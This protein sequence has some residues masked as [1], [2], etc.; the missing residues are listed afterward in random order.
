MRF[1]LKNILPIIIL[2]IAV[3]SFVYAVPTVPTTPDVVRRLEDERF[4]VS[5][6][7]V[8]SLEAEAGNVTR[9]WLYG[10][11][12]TQTWQGFY[13]EIE[14]TITLD[15]AQNWTFYDWDMV[16][17]QGEIY[18][19]SAIVTNWETVHCL[20]Y[21]AQ[22]N[23]CLNTSANSTPA[24]MH[25]G[26][27]FTDNFTDCNKTMN[28]SGNMNFS[29]NYFYWWDDPTLTPRKNTTTEI[30]LN[31]SILEFGS[32][33]WSLGL[34]W[35]DYDG[36]DETFNSSGQ[37]RANFSTGTNRWVNHSTFWVGSIEIT[38]G[39]CPATDMYEAICMNVTSPDRRDWIPNWWRMNDTQTPDLI[40]FHNQTLCDVFLGLPSA[41]NDS[42]FFNLSD[43]RNGAQTSVNLSNHKYRY[44]GSEYGVNFQEV[45]LTVNHSRTIIYAT[46]IE[47][48]Q[49]DNNTD[50]IGFDNDTHDFQLI[51]G[52]DGHAGPNQDTTTPYYFYVEIE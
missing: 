34:I 25:Q 46:I 39:T 9:I 12:Q 31:L 4:N 2:L 27:Y 35:N 37:I 32:E 40:Q 49:G 3:I 28:A 26:S 14:G 42:M 41:F 17:P 15:D 19:A 52:D 38:Q 47:N 20:N 10:L 6:H 1:A 7:G 29:Y 13:G 8:P 45:L 44:V 16:E 33:T 24:G 50:V 5:Q 21:T 11:T 18:A 43:A 48:D 23:Y 36:V 30:W 51:V 22:P